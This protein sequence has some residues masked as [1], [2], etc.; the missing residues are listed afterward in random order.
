MLTPLAEEKE[1]AQTRDLIHR[2]EKNLA[3]Q[4]R[5]F[6][7]LVE[8]MAELKRQHKT[9]STRTRLPRPLDSRKLF[10]LDVDDEIWQEDPG[11]GAQ[12]EAALPRWQTDEAVKTGIAALLE[13]RRCVE[14]LERIH[15]E[16]AALRYWWTDE[17][18]AMSAFL[19]DNAGVTCAFVRGR[20]N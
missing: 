7:A 13:E 16:A 15:A 5:K 2:R 3:A 17:E 18:A 4:V 19:A 8:Q 9:P 20:E 14:E 1:H 6:N 10:K 12:D 11:L